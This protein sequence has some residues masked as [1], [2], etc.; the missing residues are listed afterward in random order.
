[1]GV[2]YTGARDP[3]IAMSTRGAWSV[4]VSR[5]RSFQRTVCATTTDGTRTASDAE[6]I[7]V[8]RIRPPTKPANTGE[9]RRPLTATLE[10]NDVDHDCQNYSI[11]HCE[12]HLTL[13]STLSTFRL[14][15]PDPRRTALTSLIPLPWPRS[16]ES[17]SLPG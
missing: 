15:W 6:S 12:R 14:P 2:P 7:R 4:Q 16:G 13:F 10:T 11:S 1:M 3:S 9:G 8:L 5:G 17:R